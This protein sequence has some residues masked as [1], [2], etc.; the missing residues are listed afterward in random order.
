MQ[1][2]EKLVVNRHHGYKGKHEMVVY[3]AVGVDGNRE[4]ITLREGALEHRPYS[5]LRMSLGDLTSR[6][7]DTKRAAAV[8]SALL[9]EEPVG[10]SLE[11]CLGFGV[12]EK[13]KS[14]IK[15]A[16]SRVTKV[17]RQSIRVYANGEVP[18]VNYDLGLAGAAAHYCLENKNGLILP[19][20]EK[21]IP[22]WRIK[23]VIGP[24]SQ[25]C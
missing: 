9:Y 1:T 6:Y 2:W 20:R 24:I 8:L 18:G 7:A 14:F 12:P 23:G 4:K 3:F 11:I 21:Q 19:E 22:Y 25:N 15:T 5:F 10:D 17:R 13:A 16:V